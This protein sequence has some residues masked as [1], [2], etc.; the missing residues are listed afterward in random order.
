MT[1]PRLNA[2]RRWALQVLVTGER[3]D[4][5]VREAKT[6]TPTDE[7]VWCTAARCGEQLSL[8]DDVWRHSFVDDAHRPQPAPLTI[9]WQTRRWLEDHGYI[10]S[11]VTV[12]AGGATG[13]FCRLT[14]A[15]RE[16]AKEAGIG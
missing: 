12:V 11:Q 14:R 13:L 15:G 6:T 9:Y 4:R 5:A 7:T 1:R 8:V 2:T 10:T 16:L 3:T